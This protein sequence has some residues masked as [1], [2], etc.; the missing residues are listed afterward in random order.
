MAHR[1]DYYGDKLLIK[2]APELA[3]VM[4]IGEWRHARE[5]FA[6]MK[7]Q[8]M[9]KTFRS[10]LGALCSFTECFENSQ[11]PDVKSGHYKKDEE[12][13]SRQFLFLPPEKMRTALSK[14]LECWTES[15]LEFIS[16][17]AH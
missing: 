7:P 16:D 5:I 1:E 14:L 17:D 10:Y 9:E 2:W 4:P 6:D 15:P 11:K 12:F 13:Q 8:I 3:P